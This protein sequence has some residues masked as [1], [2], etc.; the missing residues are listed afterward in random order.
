LS[1][2][3]TATYA[4]SRQSATQTS[5]TASAVTALRT[6]SNT[7]QVTDNYGRTSTQVTGSYGRSST[8]VTGSYGRTS[9]QAYNSSLSWVR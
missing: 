8:Q 2:Q 7:P 1:A 5:Q 9:T 4:P 6:N 3:K